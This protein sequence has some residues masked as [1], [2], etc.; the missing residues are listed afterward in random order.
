M[1]KP[2]ATLHEAETIFEKN[3]YA[4][5]ARLLVVCKHA[6]CEGYEQ[7]I[8]HVIR[9]YANLGYRDTSKILVFFA[10]RVAW[11]DWARLVE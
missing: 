1:Q 7:S 9:Y 10:E 8:L 6:R 2:Y 4:S 11:P 5:S 3:L